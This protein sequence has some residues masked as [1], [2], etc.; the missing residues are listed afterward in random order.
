M[1]LTG[2]VE[3]STHANFD[4]TTQQ[5]D[6]TSSH[7]VITVVIR[8]RAHR[9]NDKISTRGAG[10]QAA[11]IFSGGHDKVN[12]QTHWNNNMQF[13]NL[14]NVKIFAHDIRVHKNQ[15]TEMNSTIKY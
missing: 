15:L 14:Y 5:H 4:T 3:I 9:G 7:L 6:E 10:R 13:S 2:I 8:I 1:D 12:K 11:E